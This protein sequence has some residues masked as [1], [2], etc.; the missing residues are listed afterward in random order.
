MEIN[1]DQYLK[2]FI[3]LVIKNAPEFDNFS[4]NELHKSLKL[5]EN[6]KNIFKDVTFYIR[7]HLVDNGIAN[8]YGTRKITL[9]D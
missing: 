2:K 7:K 1:R 8:M 3:P 6:D 5:S 9:T 4:V